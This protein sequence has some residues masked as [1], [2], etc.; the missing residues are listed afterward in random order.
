MVYSVR[1]AWRRVVSRGWNRGLFLAQTHRPL[2]RLAIHPP[3][4]SYH[5]IW[6]Q[7]LRMTDQ[8]LEMRVPTTYRDWLAERRTEAAETR[9]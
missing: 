9:P 8:L 3:D 4:A 5:H 1:S 6:G 7:I 2:V